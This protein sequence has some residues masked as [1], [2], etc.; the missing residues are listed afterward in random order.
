M[1]NAASKKPKGATT[2]KNHA[3]IGSGLK[4]FL[5]RAGKSFYSGG[6]WAKDWVFWTAQKSGSVGFLLAT[7]SVRIVTIKF[8][9]G[10]T[11]FKIEIMP[12]QI[13]VFISIICFPFLYSNIPLFFLRSISINNC[14]YCVLSLPRVYFFV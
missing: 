3:K 14:L 5:T 2:T 1:K 12:M 4:G 11:R 9:N 10:F 13:Y 6:V 8:C 7:T